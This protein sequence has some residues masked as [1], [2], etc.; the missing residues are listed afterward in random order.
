MP[1]ILLLVILIGT[2]P[3]FHCTCNHQQLDEIRFIE[4]DYNPYSK[5]VTGPYKWSIYEEDF[6]V[7][8]FTWNANEETRLGC[9]GNCQP[10]TKTYPRRLD[11]RTCQLCSDD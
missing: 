7:D 6:Y 4:V 3:Q 10:R 11:Q 2:L 8:P 5:T 9:L 1:I